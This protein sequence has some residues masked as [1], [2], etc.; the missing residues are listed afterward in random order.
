M[1][2]KRLGLS[3]LKVKSFVTD[4]DNNRMAQIIGASGLT[5]NL[6]KSLVGTMCNCPNI[7]QGAQVCSRD[8]C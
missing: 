7:S 6:T 3:E 8:S 4:I 5:C 2:N 1:K